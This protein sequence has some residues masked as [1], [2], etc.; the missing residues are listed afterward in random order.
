MGNANDAEISIRISIKDRRAAAKDLGDTSK[1]VENVGAKAEKSAKGLARFGGGLKKAAE[2]GHSWIKSAAGVLGAFAGFEAIEKGTEFLKESARSAIEDEAAQRKLT[3]ALRNSVGANE[4]Q[5][6]A[7]G[8]SL[9]KMS[10]QYGVS[11]DELMP[12]YERLIESTHNTARAHAELKLAMDVSAGTGKSLSVVSAALM[13]ANNGTTASLAKLGLKTKDA[14]GHT[15]K[16][17]DALKLMAQTFKGQAEAKA[18]SLDGKMQRL[19]MTI[20]ELQVRIGTWLLP[21]LTKVADFIIGKGIPMLEHFADQWQKNEGV[22]GKVHQ[23]LNFVGGL[24]KDVGGWMKKHSEDV[25]TFATVMGILVGVTW[26]LSFALD[27]IEAIL[28]IN[29]FV[30]LGIAI[31]LVITWFVHLYKHS[32]GFRNFING[33]GNV[34]KIVW[35][36]IKHNWPYLLGALIGPIGIAGVWIAKHWTQ[37]TNGIKHGWNNVMGFLKK[38]PGE[39]GGLFADAGKWLLHS[40][41]DLMN[42]LWKGI[43]KGAS[44]VGG[45]VTDLGKL[46]VNAVIGFINSTVIDP[47]DSALHGIGA[48]GVHP[49]GNKTIPDIPALAEGGII[50][51]RPGGTIVT[52]AEVGHD[53]AAV[54]LNGQR[55]YI[56]GSGVT[57]LPAVKP[58]QAKPAKLDE[59][60]LALA[61]APGNRDRRD[62]HVHLEVDGHELTEAVLEDID[63]RVGRK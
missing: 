52:M 31:A 55:Y 48:F 41:E 27:A 22:L 23:A 56:D 13:K 5:A 38:I 40:G 4:E 51:A 59:R 1:D 28:A 29:P 9:G 14:Q 32:T 36:W 3:I 50:K 25:K 60:H 2:G 21:I 63:K 57:K 20:H 35:N 6:K 24:V 16:L 8:E 46:I 12:A 37:I 58:L 19:H 39:V 47:F 7:V 62:L 49:F 18:N 17:T 15:L 45:F 10:E 42:G 43:K 61:G 34:L 44:T 30:L 26:G 53:E 54:P 11:K 33:I